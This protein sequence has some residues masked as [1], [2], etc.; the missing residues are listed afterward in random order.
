MTKPKVVWRGPEELR[1]HLVPLSAVSPHPDNPKD[2]DLGAIA[3][4]LARF[5]QKV[6][7]LVQRSTGW[8]VA[9]N[10]RWESIPMAAELERA[11]EVGPGVEWTHVAAVFD[12]LDDLE[13][14]AYALADNRTHDLG[15]YREDVLARV[16]GELATADGLVATGYDP[17]DLDN[18]LAALRPAVPFD[19][20]APED[21]EVRSEVVVEVRC[22]RAF[23]ERIRPTLDEWA[24]EEGVEVGIA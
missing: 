15:G 5:G 16:L 14:K 11:L 19:V 13:A 2:H 22:G 24:A 10:G 18:L 17:D 20:P 23:L 21:P 1:P 9:G 8:I 12:D 4:S 7:I 6:P 3:A